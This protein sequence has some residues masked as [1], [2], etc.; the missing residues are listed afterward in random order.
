MGCEHNN[1]TRSE[2][3]ALWALLFFAKEI[4][5]P[6]LH[7]YEDSSIIINWATDKETLST[8]ELDGWCDNIM[9]LK[10]FF[11][12]LDFHHVFREHNKRE[13]SLSKEAL[14]M[15]SCLFPS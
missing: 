13:Y 5:I 12:T 11:H 8:I 9:E 6:T 1:N 7:V 2:L 14:P 3:L 10:A 15:A 4:A